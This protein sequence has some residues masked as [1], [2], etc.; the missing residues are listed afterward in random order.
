LLV[1]GTDHG[2]VKA[3]S[4]KGLCGILLNKDRSEAA[5]WLALRPAGTEIVEFWS[6]PGLDVG[7][8]GVVVSAKK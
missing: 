2:C 1:V 8:S 3:E 4:M 5:D 7:V 6:V